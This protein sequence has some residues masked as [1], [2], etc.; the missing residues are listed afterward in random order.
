MQVTSHRLDTRQQLIIAN[1]LNAT[2]TQT[3]KKI[4]SLNNKR[5][6]ITTI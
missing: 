4:V 1:G 6:F 2:S 5:N 3:G